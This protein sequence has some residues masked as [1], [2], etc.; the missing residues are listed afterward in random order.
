MSDKECERI[1]E[2]LLEQYPIDEMV[3]FSELDLQEKIQDNPYQ[4]VK[5]RE[6][7]Y[8]ELAGLD[9][10]NSLYDKLVGERY[11]HYR[12]DD[13]REWTKVEIERYCLPS[14]KKIIRMK[15][16][17]RKQETK[18]RFF[19]MAFKAFEQQGWRLKS[20]ID[21]LRGGY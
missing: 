13:D 2:S 8:K 7:Y 14:D 6:L 9:K 16:I 11:K 15:S 4:I 21:T 10:M 5:F 12:F 18:V 20:F 19:E 17:I 3:K 1:L